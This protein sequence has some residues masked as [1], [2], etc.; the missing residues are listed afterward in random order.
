MR[1]KLLHKQQRPSEFDI[2]PDIQVKESVPSFKRILYHDLSTVIICPT[3]GV[4]P[5]KVVKSWFD[6]QKPFSHPIGGPIFAIGMEVGAAYQYLMDMIINNPSIN[7]WQYVLTIEEDNIPPPNGLLKLYESINGYVDG[8]KYDV[9]A[10]LYNLKGPG[11]IPLIMGDP[12]KSLNDCRVVPPKDNTVQ[13]AN[14]FGMGFTLFRLPMFQHIP[15]PWFETTSYATQDAYFLSKA[16]HRG[17]KLAVDTRVK[18]GHY[19]VKNDKV[20]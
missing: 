6:L 3:R 4:I 16:R 10:G 13:P 17:F 19:D 9:M 7:K 5:A 12:S 2:I 8:I 18:V 14:V 15:K 11:G 20:W 1:K